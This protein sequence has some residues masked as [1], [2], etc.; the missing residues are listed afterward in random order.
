MF[1]YF[2]RLLEERKH[3]PGPD[4]ISALAHGDIVGEKLT[5]LEILFNAFLLI[6]GGQETTRNTLSGGMLALM[7][8]PHNGSVSIARQHADEDHGRGI[9]ALHLADHSSHAHRHQGY[10]DHGGKIKAGDRVV[11]WNPSAN[12]DGAQFPTRPF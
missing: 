7:E 9:P 11:I 3:N 6:L 2:V 8:N 4:L 10:R 12:R 1:Q 5:D